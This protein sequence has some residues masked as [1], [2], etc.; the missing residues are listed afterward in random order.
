MVRFKYLG[1]FAA[2]ERMLADAGRYRVIDLDNAQAGTILESSPVETDSYS[3]RFCF[4]SHFIHLNG[5]IHQIAHAPKGIM[6]NLDDRIVASIVGDP[7]RDD[8]VF[9]ATIDTAVHGHPGHVPVAIL[10]LPLNELGSALFA[11][12]TNNGENHQCYMVE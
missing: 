1:Q 7:A 11:P 6:A 9:S 3:S 10:E 5:H 2:I 4:I 12:K 8:D